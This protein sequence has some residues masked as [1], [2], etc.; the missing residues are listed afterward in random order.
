[1]KNNNVVIIGLIIYK[2]PS[3]ITISP[4]FFIG[5]ILHLQVFLSGFYWLSTLDFFTINIYVK[6][7]KDLN[8]KNYIYIIKLKAH[9]YILYILC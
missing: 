4:P 8:I 6:Y 7:S 9:I 2:Y 5:G 1:M 3:N